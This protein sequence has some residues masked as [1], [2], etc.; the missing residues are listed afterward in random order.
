MSGGVPR[1]GDVVIASINRN[2]TGRMGNPD[3]EIYLASPV[4]VAAAAV[5]GMIV[6]PRQ[7]VGG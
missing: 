4:T 3:A 7:V 2:F 6:D 1:D 5:A